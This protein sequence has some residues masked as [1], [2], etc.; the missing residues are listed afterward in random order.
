MLDKAKIE[1]L[2]FIII[3]VCGVGYAYYTY[4][5]CGQITRLHELEKELD[6]KT[7]AVAE[8]R[9][10]KKNIAK[11]REKL[12]NMESE[13]LEIDQQIPNASRLSKFNMELYYYIKAHNLKVSNLEA[14]TRD[15]SPKDYGKQ[16]IEIS[17]AGKK[18][19]IIDLFT[20]FKEAP[21][22][23][24]VTE[25]AANIMDTED[26]AINIKLNTFFILKEGENE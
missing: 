5:F 12:A 16:P 20:Y 15:T 3:A 17:V 26:L 24:K 7:S 4:V 10:V 2:L 11:S 8:L 6:D 23:I 21:I 9:T 22:K 18:Q 1:K 25:C 14:K 19:D 13:F